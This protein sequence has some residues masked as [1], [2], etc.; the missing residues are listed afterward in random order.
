MGLP[1]APVW[2]V[3]PQRILALDH[4]CIMGVLNITPDSFSDGGQH[5]RVEAA[6]E[7]GLRMIRDGAGM[8]DVGGE[9]TRPGAER[10]PADLQISRV[11]PVIRA[12]RKAGVETPLSVDTTLAA[13]ARAALD[14]GADAVNDVSAGLEDTSLFSL[15]AERGAGLVLMHRVA[16]PSEDQYSTAYDRE[17]VYPTEQ[18]GVVG[19]VRAFLRARHLAAL[20]TGIARDTIALDPGL[21]FGKSV[22]QNYELVARVG[23]IVVPGD[24][25]VAGASRKSFIGA[26]SG[27]TEPRDRVWGSVAAAV[28]LVLHGAHVIRAHDVKQHAAAL[29]VAARIRAS[30]GPVTPGGVAASGL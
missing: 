15:V 6:V 7:A 16:P 5:E 8:L 21:G 13:V 14:A 22:A 20:R 30:R 11:T 23:E 19:C 28:A 2:R 27:E 26:V 29:D 24:V 10:V 18:G 1:D 4:P 9:S 3:G 17:P 12:L 25:I